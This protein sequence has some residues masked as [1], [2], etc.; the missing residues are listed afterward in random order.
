MALATLT[1]NFFHPARYVTGVP[2]N[3]AAI[4]MSMI[5]VYVGSGYG[6]GSDQESGVAMQ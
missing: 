5:G 1:M 2:E 6:R 4:G 3:E